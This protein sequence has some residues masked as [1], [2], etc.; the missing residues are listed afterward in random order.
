MNII[1]KKSSLSGHI[2]V[3]GSKSHTIRA[4]LFASLADG[5]S[6]IQNPLGGEDCLS[7]ASAVKL[8]GA[9]TDISRGDVWTIK[10][11]GKNTHLPDNVVDVG[12]SGSLLYFMAPIAAT[13]EGWSVFTGDSSIRKRPVLHLADAL[14]QFGAQA[15]ISRPAENAPPLIIKGAASSGKTITTDGR[16]SQYVSGIMMAAM[17]LD[18]T[19]KIELTD[20][21]ETPFLN[22]TRLWLE[23][24]GANIKISDDYRHIEIRGKTEIP[25]FNRVI[26]SDW[27]AAAFPLV[28]ALITGSEI[29]IDNID[30]SGSQGDAIVADILKSIGANIK[31]E[32]GNLYVSKSRLS[33]RNLKNGELHANLSGCPDA[34]CALAAA[35]CFTEGTCVFE[36][37]K[38]CRSKETD[39]IE[40][41]EKELRALGANI[42]TG[43][44]Y[45]AVH[46]QPQ[47]LSDGS[48]NPAFA[49]HGCIAE[50]YGDHR[51]AMSL[52]C[53]SLALPEGQNLTI[54]DS[55]CCAVSFPHFYDV[56]KKCGAD[57]TQN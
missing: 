22:M 24:F 40:V 31:I 53:I 48:K 52:A 32:D 18:G 50:S 10:G 4:L 45:L 8:F 20:P 25:A 38:V 36:D 57:F 41:M 5:T 49:M 21:K 14:K 6:Q 26:P 17:R 7:A 44:D 33:T 16:L 37:I 1:G 34:L 51:V 19:T 11:A 39:R 13:F 47:F 3:P 9:E 30:N 35:S 28:A 27:E 29:V 12:N 43:E 56:M 46:G 42:E 54:K 23:S 55:E 15:Y 2:Q